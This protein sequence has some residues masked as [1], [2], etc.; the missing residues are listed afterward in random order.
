MNA[1]RIAHRTDPGPRENLEDSVQAVVLE[2][3]APTRARIPIAM[4]LDGA[5]GHNAGEI[6][7]LLGTRLIASTLNGA[8]AG[9]A[10]GTPQQMPS[11]S[12]SRFLAQALQAANAAV[13]RA[14]TERPEH[15]DMATTAVCFVVWD[16]TLYAA[17][18]GDSRCYIWR[19]GKIH[20][21][22]RDHTTVQGMIDEG[23]L[24]VAE[25]RF[26]PLAHIIDQCLGMADSFT[27]G[28]ASFPLSAGDI[29]LLCSDGLT[30]VMTDADLA[31]LITY[32][33]GN[34]IS[35]LPRRLVEEALARSTADNVTVLCYQHQPE[36]TQ[37]DRLSQ[38]VTGVYPSELAMVFQ[39]LS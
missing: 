14:S 28:F 35:G 34:G 24:T 25:A 12:I 21:L 13:V 30:D 1:V 18:A 6:A 39:R 11:E 15:R 16:D 19:G 33:A 27:P 22:T 31:D 17:W 9:W 10:V 26:H 7:S 2:L 4:L 32:H 29:V 37:L 3:H 8:L 5:G 20:R 38:T 36:G 23:L